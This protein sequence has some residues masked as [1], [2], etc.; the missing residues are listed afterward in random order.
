MSERRVRYLIQ[1]CLKDS[2]PVFD[3]STLLSSVGMNK[4]YMSERRV[5]LQTDMKK[6]LQWGF[7]GLS[8]EVLSFCLFRSRTFFLHL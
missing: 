3:L 5:R 2:L 7:S 4:G 6:S 8:L 1:P